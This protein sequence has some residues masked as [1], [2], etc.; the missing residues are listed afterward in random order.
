MTSFKFLLVVLFVFNI[1]STTAQETAID[2]T[3]LP[4]LQKAEFSV[5]GFG[6]NYE[7]PV[8]K[9]LSLDSGLGFSSGAHIPKDEVKFQKSVFNPSFY[10]KTEL[11]YYY[12]RYV[13]IAKKLPTRNGEGSYFAFQNKFL[14]QRLFDSK[15]PLST[16]M[17]YEV[18]WGIQRN[19]Y[20]NFL[21]NFHVG[22]GHSY[23]FT[24]TGSAFYT[25]IGL[26]AFYILS[27]KKITRS[28]FEKFW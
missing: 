4:Y 1:F 28:S 22:I 11:K 27:S 3:A 2:T 16:I 12:N 15:T 8:S 13:R 6:A 19:V 26:K 21:F 18:H 7:F 10:V 5:L 24:T 14:T 25:A 9:V 20:K 23:D 17:M